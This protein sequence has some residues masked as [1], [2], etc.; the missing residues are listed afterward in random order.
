MKRLISTKPLRH[1]K[2]QLVS[3]ALAAISVGS[4]S[5]SSLASSLG[6]QIAQKMVTLQNSQ[7]R[8][9]QVDISK[10]RLIAWEGGSPIYAVVVSTGKNGTPTRPGTFTV[11]S[12]HRTNRMRGPGYDVPD[13]P[14]TMYYHR[15][16]AIH[17]AYWHRQFGT[18]MSHGCVN[19]APNHAAWLFNWA[20]VGTPVVIHK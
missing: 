17:G 16:Y 14:H 20:S 1:Y 7:D 4:L 11:Q 19:V 18:P 9:I 2:T 8:W 10:Q 3:V 13:V 15:G 6:D 5:L 12:K